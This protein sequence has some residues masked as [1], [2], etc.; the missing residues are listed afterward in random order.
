M[1]HAFVPSR[2]NF[3]CRDFLYIV[4]VTIKLN[5]CN[6]ILIREEEYEDCGQFQI[7][8]KYASISAQRARKYNIDTAIWSQDD[9]PLDRTKN[10]I[11]KTGCKTPQIFGI[12]IEPNA[13]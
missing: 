6:V 9:T 11:C 8:S 4:S 3:S 13:L 7:E 1:S 2:L 5:P 12:K 10:E